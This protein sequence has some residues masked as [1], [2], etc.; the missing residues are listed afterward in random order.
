MSSRGLDI[1]FVLG[2]EFADFSFEYEIGLGFLFATD[3]LDDIAFVVLAPFRFDFFCQFFKHNL[4][5]TL[6]RV[7]S[8]SLRA[9]VVPDRERKL[10]FIAGVHN[11]S[12]VE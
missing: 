1:N 8:Y 4:A 10:A 6:A 2:L 9:R 11:A 3:A 7:E 12:E 5:E